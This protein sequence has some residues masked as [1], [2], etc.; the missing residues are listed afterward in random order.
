[1]PRLPLS[2]SF[3]NML[4]NLSV[5]DENA[6]NSESKMMKLILE[7]TKQ[8]LT[9]SISIMEKQKAL[10]STVTLL[11]NDIKVLKSLQE[12]FKPNMKDHD[13]EC[14]IEDED[15]TYLQ[16]VA[17]KI[18]GLQ[19]TKNQYAQGDDEEDQENN[20]SDTSENE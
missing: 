5:D 6:S 14:I 17:K 11:T 1:M 15:K 12:N 19:P 20:K 9:Q 2:K 16:M 18:F 8:I 4:E 7:M 3:T 13:R 10:E